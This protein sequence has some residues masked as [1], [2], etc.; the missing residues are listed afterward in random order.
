MLMTNEMAIGNMQKPT[1]YALVGDGVDDYL[2]TNYGNGI[3]LNVDDITVEIE[4]EF[5]NVGTT[6][7]IQDIYWGEVGTGDNNRIYLGIYEGYFS[8][9]IA[10]LLH[11]N[12]KSNKAVQ[13]NKNY[14]IKI[15]FNNSGYDLY[16]NEDLVMQNSYTPFIT[17]ANFYLLNANGTGVRSNAQIFSYRVILNNTV[18]QSLD[19][20]EGS[21]AN[22]KDYVG[23]N[24]ATIVGATWQ[25]VD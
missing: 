24:D 14:L 5:L 11:T 18:V 23:S 8:L 1:E 25:E 19:M 4:I 22:V 16:I 13:I 2:N 7:D 6:G 15:D 21:G 17:S 3:D 9:G 10:N 12:N 20:N